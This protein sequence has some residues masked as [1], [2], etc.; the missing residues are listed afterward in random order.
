MKDRVHWTMMC[1]AKT[2]KTQLSWPVQS[3]ELEDPFLGPNA[4]CLLERE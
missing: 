1:S 4:P 3:R 2:L